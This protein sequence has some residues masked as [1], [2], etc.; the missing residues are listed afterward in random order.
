[1]KRSFEEVAG[2]LQKAGLTRF[3]VGPVE[4]E[5][6]RIKGKMD[7]AVWAE[8]RGNPEF[9][10]GPWHLLHKVGPDQ[11]EYRSH[12]GVYG[13]G[14]LQVVYSPVTGAF[15]ADVD[16]F[17][18][19]EDVVGAFGHLLGEVVPNTVK[20]WFKGRKAPESA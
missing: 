14:S 15:E 13:E 10:S 7:L 9:R 4:V 16:V 19:Y 3:I 8:L 12:R 1:M 11:T 20:K 2:Q 18:P 6:M 5:P 17:N